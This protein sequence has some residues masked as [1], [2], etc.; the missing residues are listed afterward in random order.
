MLKLTAG[1]KEN[2]EFDLL[3]LNAN[4]DTQKFLDLYSE[5]RGHIERGCL[6]DM[7]CFLLECLAS[8]KISI[9]SGFLYLL[10]FNFGP[11][12]KSRQY[13]DQA[14]KIFPDEDFWSDLAKAVI[15]D[16]FSQAEKC[17]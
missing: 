10:Y 5:I 4:F 6:D 12:E 3:E 14:K 8:K 1:I 13:F 17:N 16:E 2:L 9:S 11:R 15:W 7:E